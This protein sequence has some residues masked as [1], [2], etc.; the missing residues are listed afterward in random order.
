MAART[1]AARLRVMTAPSSDP[2]PLGRPGSDPTS[3]EPGSPLRVV[4]VDPDDRTRQSIVGILG[5]RD[6]FRV[7]GSAGQ[8]DSAVDL[9]RD[10]HP[11]V[12]ILDPRLPEATGGMSLIR[13]IRGIE[14]GC[15]ILAV[16]WS[17]QLEEDAIGA[18]ADAF[19]RK[20]F[21]PGDLADAIGRCMDAV[22]HDA[23]VGPA[24]ATTDAP[25]SSPRSDRSR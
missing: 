22:R 1:A 16:G 6:R 8:L 14:P 17:P 10:R 18:G 2:G 24:P 23:T 12:V 4:V 13:T 25:Q 5:I 20:T 19:V 15:R 7:V 21:R 3:L 9:V 11:D